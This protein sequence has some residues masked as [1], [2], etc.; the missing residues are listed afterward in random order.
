MKGMKKKARKRIKPRVSLSLLMLMSSCSIVPD[1]RR[2]SC[3][4]QSGGDKLELCDGTH[5]EMVAVVN[6]FDRFDTT[7]IHSLFFS[8]I[9][10]AAGS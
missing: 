5:T 6:N 10:S 3:C 9:L 1:V 4:R 8:V 2:L 7:Q